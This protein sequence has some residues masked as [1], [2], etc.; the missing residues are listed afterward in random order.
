MSFLTQQR[1]LA[2]VVERPNRFTYLEQIIH[3]RAY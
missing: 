3:E 1:V 2:Y